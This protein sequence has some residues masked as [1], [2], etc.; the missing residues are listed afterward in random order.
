VFEFVLEIAV[1]FEDLLEIVA[2]VGHAMFELVHFM[3]D[4]L[5]TTKRGER[6]LVNRRTGLEVNMLVQ[7]TQLHAARTHHITTIRGFITSDETKDR[8]L[9]GAIAAYQS[10]VLARIHLQRRAAQD[11]LNAVRFMNL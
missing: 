10:N 8:A 7:Q 9:T 4:L 11:V 1:T 5:E 2:G 3:F 6:R